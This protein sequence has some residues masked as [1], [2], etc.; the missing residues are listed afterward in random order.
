M[1]LYTNVL[2]SIST[3]TAYKNI[4][5]MNEFQEKHEENFTTDDFYA[6]LYGEISKETKNETN[7]QIIQKECYITFEPLETKNSITLECN[8]TFNYSPLFKEIYNQKYK[9]FIHDSI[10]LKVNTIKCPYCRNIQNSILPPHPDFPS[11]YGVNSPY[12][13]CMKVNECKYMM[14]SGKNKGNVCGLSC[15][16]EYCNKHTTLLKKRE[17]KKNS[18]NKKKDDTKK[19]CIAILSNGKNKGNPCGNKVKNDVDDYCGKH[20]KMNEKTI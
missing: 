6:L 16:N 17:E 15:L 11:I 7:N 10:R 9:S 8:H 1:S 13:F 3:T 18:S 5:S 14:L 4:S 20:K 19:C 2:S 12:N